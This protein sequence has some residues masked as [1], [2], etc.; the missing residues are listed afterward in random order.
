MIFMGYVSFRE[1]NNPLIWPYFVG[2]K[3]LAFGIPQPDSYEEI[4]LP[5]Q[6]DITNLQVV[7]VESSDHATRPRGPKFG[8]PRLR[9]G[10]KQSN[11]GAI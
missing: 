10:L 11:F 3:N 6:S 1:G 5:D 8:G 4:E 9:L 2:K 7:L